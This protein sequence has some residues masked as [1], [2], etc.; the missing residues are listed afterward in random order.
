[1]KIY[2]TKPVERTEITC[3]IFSTLSFK[4]W[5]NLLRLV[6]HACEVY[7]KKTQWNSLFKRGRL[8]EKAGVFQIFMTSPS[9]HKK[10]RKRY[11]RIRGL[12]SSL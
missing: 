11:T 3:N 1:M 9:V 2:L 12:L 6:V 8:F 10:N 5:Y 4:L 7:C